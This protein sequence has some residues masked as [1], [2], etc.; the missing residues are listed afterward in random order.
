LELVTRPRSFPQRL[1]E[2][3]GTPTLDF[4]PG[5]ADDAFFHESTALITTT[6]FTKNNSFGKAVVTD[7]CCEI[8]KDGTKYVAFRKSSISLISTVP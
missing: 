7:V 6:S 1:Q 8:F 3:H 2:I 5:L 4:P